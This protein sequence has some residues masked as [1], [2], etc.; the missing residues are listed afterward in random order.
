MLRRQSVASVEAVGPDSASD[1]KLSQNVAGVRFGRI[2]GRC[3]GS[4]GACVL[5][6]YYEH[7]L[8]SEVCEMRHR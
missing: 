2:W 5:G 3:E 4:R 6:L 8:E 7:C 1:T